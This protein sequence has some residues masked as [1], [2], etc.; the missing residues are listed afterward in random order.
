MKKALA[1]L[2]LFSALAAL[3][4]CGGTSYRTDVKAGDLIQTA[5]TAL[6]DGVT[7]RT[8][9][10]SYLKSYFETPDYVTESV[11]RFAEDGNNVNEFGI[12]LVKDGNAKAMSA[13]L[14]GY[15]DD[16]YAQFGTNYKQ[17]E[18]PKLRDAEVRVYGNYAVYAILT[19]SDRETF[20]DAVRDALT[21]PQ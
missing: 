11:I 16:Y 15:L 13:L 5:E 4:A 1:L 12:F 20:F 8:A 10:N 6:G 3:A 9:L 18:I 19:G 14:R 2:L 7:Y 17:E 21:V